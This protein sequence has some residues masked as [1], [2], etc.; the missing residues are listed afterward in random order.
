MNET[1]GICQRGQTIVERATILFH[2]SE[3]QTDRQSESRAGLG[4]FAQEC[5]RRAVSAGDTLHPESKVAQQSFFTQFCLEFPARRTNQNNAGDAFAFDTSHVPARTEGF[6][7]LRKFAVT[8]PT[9][10]FS[11]AANRPQ[12]LIH[13]HRTSQNRKR[14]PRSGS[15]PSQS[16]CVRIDSA[17][18]GCQC[19]KTPSQFFLPSDYNMPRRKN[20]GETEADRFLILQPLAHFRSLNS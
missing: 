6:F 16:I 20:C 10:P 18:K 1:C 15:S 19:S 9:V 14:P 5:L 12:G 11:R 8:I 7:L 17:F 13:I 2:T 3:L 4:P